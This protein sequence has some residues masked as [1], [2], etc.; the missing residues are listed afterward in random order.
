MVKAISINQ[1]P[2]CVQGS[3]ARASDA[4]EVWIKPLHDGSF[5]VVLLNKSLVRANITLLI[6][7]VN[8]GGDFF[9]ASLETVHVRDIFRGKDLGQH[10]GSFSAWVDGHDALLLRVTPV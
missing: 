3:L 1:D 2:D 8:N 4:S 10:S 9:P 6:S 7:A 5:A